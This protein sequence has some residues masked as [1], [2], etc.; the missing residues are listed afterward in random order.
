MSVIRFAILFVM[1]FGCAVDGESTESQETR[2]QT[3]EDDDGDPTGGGTYPL[4]PTATTALPLMQA[5]TTYRDNRHDEIQ[6]TK[7]VGDNG[8]VTWV[9]CCT[10]DVNEGESHFDAYIC[11][12]A[13]TNG[14]VIHCGYGHQLSPNP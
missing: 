13:A 7:S 5:L 14:G 10:G 6:C 1:L 4:D 3:C 12:G 2:C 11:C 8:Q 9:E